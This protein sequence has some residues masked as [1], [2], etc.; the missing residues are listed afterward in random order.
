MNVIQATRRHYAWL[1]HKPAPD[2][3]PLELTVGTNPSY[4]IWV[5]AATNSQRKAWLTKATNLL[6]AMYPEVS[7]IAVSFLSPSYAVEVIA[8]NSGKWAGNALLFTSRDGAEK[9][10]DDLASRWFAVREWR[11]VETWK[12]ATHFWDYAKHKAERM[13]S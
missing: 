6:R 2:R 11:V 8:D 13:P 1:Q 3:I 12:P 9:Y 5:K 7:R 4:R 10:A